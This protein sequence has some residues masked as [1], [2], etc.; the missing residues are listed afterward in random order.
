MRQLP[1][2]FRFIPRIERR[3]EPP[4]IGSAKRRIFERSH[5]Y[6]VT[7]CQ[8]MMDRAAQSMLAPAICGAQVIPNGVDL[9]FY[10]PR[11]KRHARLALNIP[12]SAKVLSFVAEGARGNPFKDWRTQA[13]ALNLLAARGSGRRSHFSVGWRGRNHSSHRSRRDSMHTLH[14]GSTAIGPLLSGIRRICSLCSGGDLPSCRHRSNGL[15][16]RRSSPHAWAASRRSS[17][18]RRR[19]S[20]LILATRQN[21]QTRSISC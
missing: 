3:I 20:W 8:W 1:R 21:L 16:R 18:T 5:L 13:A 9:G 10:C 15:R 14:G 12:L 7:P 4:R 11:D 17:A 2:S 6:V 19:G